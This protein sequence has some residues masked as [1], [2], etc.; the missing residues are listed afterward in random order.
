ML[1]VS[2]IINSTLWDNQ[3]KK[4]VSRIRSTYN[5]NIWYI[6]F[7]VMPKDQADVVT[8]WMLIKNVY[9]VTDKNSTQFARLRDLKMFFL[10]VIKD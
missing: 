4:L 6:I 5:V 10:V 3:I 2:Y 7:T 8:S 1:L 9:D